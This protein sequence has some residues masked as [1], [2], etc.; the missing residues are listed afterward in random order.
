MEGRWLWSAGS[1]APN[2]F[3]APTPPLGWV[4]FPWMFSALP[5]TFSIL[6]Q[7]AARRKNEKQP[8]A[9]SDSDSAAPQPAPGVQ[10]DLSGPAEPVGLEQTLTDGPEVSLL[11]SFPFFW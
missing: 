4:K 11:S 5:F 7:Q 2:T 1:M 9:L 3:R 8:S 10:G 6:Q